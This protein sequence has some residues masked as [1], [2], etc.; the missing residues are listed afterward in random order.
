MSTEIKDLIVILPGIMGSVLEK[1]GKVIWDISGKSFLSTIQSSKEL[2]LKSD[3][4]D[5]G[6]VATRV[7][8]DFYIVPGIIKIIDG[9]TRL[10]ECLLGGTLRIYPKSSDNPDLVNYYE[11][12]YDWRRDNRISAHKLKQ[13]IDERLENWRQHSEHKDAQVILL[14]HSMGGLVSRYYL[15][16]LE[17]W[18]DCRA[19]LTFGTP[20]RG[21]AKVMP[22]IVEGYQK[23]F[24]DFTEAVRSFTSVYQLLPIYEMFKTDEG[25]R[26]V[27]EVNGIPNLDRDRAIKARKFHQEIEDHVRE[28]RLR[29][30]WKKNGY[31]VLPFVGT[32][33]AT[34]QSA[35]LVNGKLEVSYDPPSS[36][37]PALADGDDSVPRISAIPLE[38]DYQDYYNT[39]VSCHHGEIQAN[40]DV[41]D[42]VKERLVQMQIQI[43]LSQ[44]K[45][46]EKRVKAEAQVSLNLFV[47]D[48][49]FSGN[50]V[51]ISG[52]VINA[53]ASVKKLVTQIIPKTT[54][55]EPITTEL[56]PDGNQWKVTLEGLAA[57]VYEV[58]LSTPDLEI[59]PVRDLFEVV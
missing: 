47:K 57:G 6:V 31:V 53:E 20:Y 41:L 44:F 24:L 7:M 13:F 54:Q 11:F 30:D 42:L 37:P 14:A 45:G 46:A 19:L 49:Y 21:S 5:D 18:R 27:S 51:E 35:T 56:Q 9:Y 34:Y 33:Q 43:D 12:P 48:L 36:L 59:T 16:V 8:Q 28:N 10:R 29:P 38:M 1:N 52:K 26:R 40:P 39:F 50:P 4:W 25:Y 3:D 2:I 32:R 55:N 15:E 58:Q 17:G 22:A 23:T